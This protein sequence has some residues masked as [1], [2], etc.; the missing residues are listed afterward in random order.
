MSYSEDNTFEKIIN[1]NWD[2]PNVGPYGRKG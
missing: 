2:D 1:L